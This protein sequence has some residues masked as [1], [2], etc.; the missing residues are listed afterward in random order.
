M[1]LR[2]LLQQPEPQRSRF[3]LNFFAGRELA[4]TFGKDF[5]RPIW[6]LAQEKSF[7]APA[8]ARPPSHQPSRHDSRVVEHEQIA[9]IQQLRQVFKNPILDRLGG[10]AND[11]KARFVAFWR[12]FLGDELG[13]KMVVE[14]IS[15][16]GASLRQSAV[17]ERNPTSQ[18]S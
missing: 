14:E 3:D 9:G 18:L 5:P 10:P 11:K 1:S 12:W 17:E 4:A 8:G 7:P 6:K 2:G 15:S 16:H 13:G